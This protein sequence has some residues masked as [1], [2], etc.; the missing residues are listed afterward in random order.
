MAYQEIQNNE[1]GLSVRNKLNSMFN[2]LYQKIARLFRNKIIDEDEDT[3]V[4]VEVTPDGDKI[5]AKANQTDEGVIQ[6][7][8]NADGQKQM[9][10][11]AKGE[12]SLQGID[13]SQPQQYP[14]IKWSGGDI[15]LPGYGGVIDMRIR[16]DADNISGTGLS[17]IN[18]STSTDY[19]KLLT[20]GVYA[21]TIA[22]IEHR[23]IGFDSTKLIIGDKNTNSHLIYGIYLEASNGSVAR[24]DGASI[25]IRPGQHDVGSGN[26][27]DGNVII[28]DE[29][30]GSYVGIGT[31]SPE[32]KLD[33]IDTIKTQ[34]RRIAIEQI[35][36]NIQLTKK[37]HY[38]KADAS[39]NNLIITLPD[40]NIG[41][42]GGQQYKIKCIADNNGSYNVQVNDNSGNNV[43]TLAEGDKIEIIFNDNN[44]EVW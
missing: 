35:N 16:A 10:I 30:D 31:T 40:T 14:K 17:I 38:I 5:I 22:H 36:A 27:S 29:Y 28:A 11:N 18:C 20:K 19:L 25:Y 37:H 9:A 13:M 12:L 43:I 33:I 2:E 23:M 8:R 7:W 6:E 21:R 24:C 4:D 3:F 41:N 39:S 26:G 1:G 15:L 34:G 42:W 44:W 32:E